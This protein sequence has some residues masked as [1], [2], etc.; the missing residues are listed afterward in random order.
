MDFGYD[1]NGVFPSNLCRIG[2]DLLPVDMENDGCDGGGGGDSPVISVGRKSFSNSSSPNMGKNHYFQVQQK[3]SEILDVIGEQSSRAQGLNHVITSAAKMRNQDDHVAYLLRDGN[4]VL[5]LLKVGRKNLFLLDDEGKQNEM[6]PMCIL[7]FYVHESRQRMGCGLKLFR[8]MLRDKRV[9]PRF[10][11][12]DRP[13]PKLISF[14]RKHYNLTK[15]IPQVNHYHIFDGFF[16]DR[17]DIEEERSKTPK[18]P[19]IYMGK[20]QYV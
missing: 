7:D 20:L 9:E 16:H 15:N 14:F 17:P 4:F 3:I 8:T 6:F 13:S 11:A 5:G 1:L 10:L 19:R 18:K 2:S 12:I